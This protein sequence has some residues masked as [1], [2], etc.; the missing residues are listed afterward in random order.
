M[1]IDELLTQTAKDMGFTDE[2]LLRDA[3]SHAQANAGHGPN[4]EKKLNRQL[5]AEEIVFY[6]KYMVMIIT[7]CK[8]VP[9]FKEQ[10]M[11]LGAPLQ[12]EN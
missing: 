7:F 11:K 6:R 4:I 8:K 3:S 1:T 5:S 12:S 10:F 9:G 2:K